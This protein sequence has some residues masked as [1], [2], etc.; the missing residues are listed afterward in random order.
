VVCA[1][2]AAARGSLELVDASA[3][4]P[5]LER[6]PG[7]KKWLVID[8]QNRLV[9]NLA[10]ARRMEGGRDARGGCR[11][12]ASMWP[13]PAKAA[14]PLE[15]C[16]RFLPHLNNAGGFFVALFR[17][18]AP[19]PPPS[20]RCASPEAAAAVAEA[21]ASRLDAHRSAGHV[22]RPLQPSEAAEVRRALALDED[23][24]AGG[25]AHS[26]LFTRSPPQEGRLGGGC[27]FAMPPRVAQLLAANPGSFS[28]VH[29]GTAVARRRKQ[30]HIG[31]GGEMWDELE[32][33]LLQPWKRTKVR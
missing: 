15:R 27:V 17:K 6:R 22:L 19:L 20:K 8:D 11:F 29:A 23:A 18:V 14:P 28:V 10:H 24:F 30:R 25:A 33:Q 21:R 4:L 12:R 7:M 5:Q 13:P 26:A 1:L 3:L 9:N 16:M 32:P 2:L 31:G